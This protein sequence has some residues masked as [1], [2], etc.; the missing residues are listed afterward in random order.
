MTGAAAADLGHTRADDALA[1]KVAEDCARV[2][3]ALVA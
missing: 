3:P 1:P 2:L